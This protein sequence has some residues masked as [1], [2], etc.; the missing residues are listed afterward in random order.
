MGQLELW[1]PVVDSDGTPGSGTVFNKAFYDSIRDAILDEVFDP[2]NPTTKVKNL[3]AEMAAAR[4]SKASLDERFD[5]A[6]NEDGTLKAIAGVVSNDTLARALP[7][8]YLANGD[9]LIWPNG[10]TAAPAYMTLGAGTISRNAGGPLAPICGDNWALMGPNSQLS[11]YLVPVGELSAA[12][13]RWA[14]VRG[15]KWS[16]GGYLYC[17]AASIGKITAADGVGSAAAY[18]IETGDAT[19][20]ELSEWRWVAGTITV[21]SLASHLRIIVSNVGG[22]GNVLFQGLTMIPGDVLPKAYIPCPGRY[23]TLTYR[24][25]GTLPLGV[26]WAGAH[27][28]LGDYA[29]NRASYIK[30]VRIDQDTAP[31]TTATKVDVKV[32]TGAGAYTSV[33]SGSAAAPTIAVAA[34]HGSSQPDGTYQRRCLQGAFGTA[35]PAG[36][37]VFV[38]IGQTDGAAPGTEL[39]VNVRLF[40][41]E[42]PFEAFYE[43]ND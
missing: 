16:F 35:F 17:S 11:E 38:D 2:A 20:Q 27:T 12:N 6:H 13:T 30:D 37:K 25:S 41:Y 15:T 23:H 14:F 39:G 8:N 40:Q 1:P 32:E 4:G 5:I 31:A 3:I 29:P 43:Y 28:K 24:Y 19:I 10:D 42:R 9:L 22:A 34:K 36:S 33:F 21:D 7:L 26:T 18:D